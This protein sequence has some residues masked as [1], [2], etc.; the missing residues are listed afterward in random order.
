M[1]TDAPADNLEAKI[2]ELF[3][4]ERLR[5]ARNKHR[6][7]QSGRKGTRYE[8]YFATYRIAEVA[9]EHANSD[10][11]KPEW[12]RIE[13]QAV[14]FVDDLVIVTVV[15]SQHSQCKNS[16]AISWAGGEHPIA[17]DF[18][19]QR[20][21]AMATGKPN[22][23]MELVVSD[24]ALA[25]ELRKSIPDKIGAYSSVRL[26]PY[27]TTAHRLVLEDKGIQGTL[28]HL[29]RVE[30]PELDELSAAFQAILLSWIETDAQCSMGELIDRAR[31]QSPQ[32]LRTFPVTDGVEHLRSEFV[33]AL[34][35]VNNLKYSVKR[36]FFSWH[37]SG[38]SGT[39]EHECGSAE[40]ARFQ[41]RV[42][43]HAPSDF[44]AFW[45]LL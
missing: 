35:S 30:N 4:V 34:A 1:A 33:T 19:M 44:D 20:A 8:D 38:T 25:E 45:D 27:A 18:E 13:G 31:K 10:G 21:L 14:G 5:Y 37:S 22:P 3:G 29:T 43:K 28:S 16:A 32:L 15:D 11:E 42:I 2:L 6:G 9:A 7:G 26:F 24:S 23:T 12:P 39:F 36:G 41:E 40:F 17:D